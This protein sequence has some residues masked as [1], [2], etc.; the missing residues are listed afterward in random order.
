MATGKLY[1][2]SDQQFICHVNYTFQHESQ[3]SWWGELSSVE[4]VHLDDGNSYVM[5]LDDSRKAKCTLKKQINH[6]VSGIP[7]RYIYRFSGT[8]GFC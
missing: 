7:P 6:A 3:S 2:Y 1:R 8:R 4:Y 5:E